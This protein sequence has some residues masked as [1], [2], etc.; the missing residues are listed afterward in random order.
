MINCN[1]FSIRT[2]IWKNIDVDDEADVTTTFKAVIEDSNNY[3][4][5]QVCLN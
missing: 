1:K 2:R 3:Y 5:K 4:T